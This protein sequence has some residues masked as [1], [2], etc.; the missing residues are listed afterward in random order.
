MFLD[1][2]MVCLRH[3]IGLELMGPESHWGRR[4]VAQS[5]P[6]G[7]LFAQPLPLPCY[8]YV[9]TVTLEQISRTKHKQKLIQDKGVLKWLS[10]CHRKFAFTR[11]NTVLFL[12][13]IKWRQTSASWNSA[14]SPSLLYHREI[15]GLGDKF[16]VLY[17][18]PHVALE[19]Y[20]LEIP[21]FPWAGKVTACWHT[22]SAE[23]GTGWPA[24]SSH[25]PCV[26]GMG[27]KSPNLASNSS[28]G[29]WSGNVANSTGKEC[30]FKNSFPYGTSCLLSIYYW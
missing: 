17:D 10:L 25:L 18:N 14:L 20:S 26:H 30:L 23:E 16:L 11:N 19:S 28:Y 6:D 12:K 8:H 15:Q 13:S 4:C 9:A 24:A 22:V 2:Q 3:Q 7:A 21:T 5:W 1:G 27:S 29:T